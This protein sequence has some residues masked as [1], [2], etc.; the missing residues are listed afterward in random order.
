MRH[1]TAIRF[2]AL[3]LVGLPAIFAACG[4]QPSEPQQHGGPLGLPGVEDMLGTYHGTVQAARGPADA[5][6]AGITVENAGDGIAG[7]GIAGDLYVSAE[8]IQ[9]GDTIVLGFQSTY[10]GYWSPHGH[11]NLTLILDD[12]V[13]GG[14]TRFEGS[15]SPANSSIEVAGRY[16]QRNADGCVR[17]A[18]FDLTISVRKTPDC[19]SRPEPGLSRE[20]IEEVCEPA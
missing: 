3:F 13:C 6:H 16:V 12:P 5:G 2:R 17:I 9:D 18:T 1:H 15:Y 10:T 11:P 19:D 8:W 20:G 7:D 4:D 14:T